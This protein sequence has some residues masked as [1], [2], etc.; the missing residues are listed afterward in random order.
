MSE[1]IVLS[2]R[3]LGR[4]LWVSHPACYF[5]FLDR[6]LLEKKSFLIL[7]SAFYSE[8]Q[9]YLCKMQGATE[10][11]YKDATQEKGAT[12]IFEKGVRLT[13]VLDGNFLGL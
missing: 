6:F 7:I 2:K 9:I 13:E 8:N 12:Q 11:K 4:P 10:K 5:F 3:T 1:D